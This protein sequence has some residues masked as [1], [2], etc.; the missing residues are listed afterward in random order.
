MAAAKP[1]RNAYLLESRFRTDRESGRE[2]ASSATSERNSPADRGPSVSQASKSSGP[3]RSINGAFDMALQGS[4]GTIFFDGL[5]KCSEG[6]KHHLDLG[7]AGL[8]LIAVRLRNGQ[9]QLQ[10]IDGIETESI[11]EQ[12]GLRSDGGR[13]R[14]KLEGPYDQGGHFLFQSG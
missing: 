8:D 1:T 14:L 11:A 9:R 3:N 5:R 7:I 12:R 6:G 4:L 13:I 2:S 10:C